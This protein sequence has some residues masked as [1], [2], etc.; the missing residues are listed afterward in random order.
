MQQ[1]A[2]HPGPLRD[3][4]SPL[5]QTNPLPPEASNA[6]PPS[7]PEAPPPD[8]QPARGEAAFTALKPQLDALAQDQLLRINTDVEAAAIVA[9]GVGQRVVQLP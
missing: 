3:I 4:P 9:L 8:Y 6:V 7:N 1:S 2:W 5:T